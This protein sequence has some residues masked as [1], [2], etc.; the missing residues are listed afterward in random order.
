MD[1]SRSTAWAKRFGAVAALVFVGATTAPALE[2]GVFT[3]AVHDRSGAPVAGAFVTATHRALQRGTTVF[4]D[5]DGRFRLP[6]LDAGMYDLRVR[7]IGYKDLLQPELSLED[8]TTRLDLRAD[9]E[10]DPNEL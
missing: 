1:Q 2:T 5:A 6:A 3:G 4:T 10:A 7:R 9:V 8:G